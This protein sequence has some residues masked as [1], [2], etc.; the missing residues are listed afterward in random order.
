MGIQDILAAKAAAANLAT[1]VQTSAQLDPVIV[2]DPNLD[3]NNVPPVPEEPELLPGPPGSYRALR[4]QR[5]F[6]YDGTKVEPNAE[7]FYIPK[8]EEERAEL[9]HFAKQWGMVELQEGE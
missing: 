8:D 2:E 6:K 9:E 4:L 5:F 7:G 1:G 3:P